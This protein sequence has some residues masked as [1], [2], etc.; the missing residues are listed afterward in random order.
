MIKYILSGKRVLTV[1]HAQLRFNR[2]N[3]LVE[4]DL[5]IVDGQTLVAEVL[6]ILVIVELNIKQSQLDTNK[7]EFGSECRIF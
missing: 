6:R 1:R 4:D 2:I 3:G 7:Q 5:H